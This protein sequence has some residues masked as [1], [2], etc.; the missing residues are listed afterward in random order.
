VTAAGGH[1]L[2]QN[3]NSPSGIRLHAREILPI[4]DGELGDANPSRFGKRSATTR[5]PSRLHFLRFEE[6]WVV[7]VLPV[8][9][10][11]VQEVGDLDRGR[12]QSLPW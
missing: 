2:D 12:T 5:S 6:V 11:D 3:R 4:V 9:F 8:D 1:S 7:E 10:G